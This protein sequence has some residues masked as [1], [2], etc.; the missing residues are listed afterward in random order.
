MSKPECIYPASV[1]DPLSARMADDLGFELGMF[2]GSVASLTVLGD[3]DLILLTLSEFAEQSYRINRACQL[4]LLVDSDHGYGNALNVMRTVEELETAGV[5][6]LSIED[7]QLPVA[8]GDPGSSKLISIEEGIGKMHA[9]VQARSDKSML[10]AARTSATQISNLDDAKARIREYQRTGVDA[11]FIVGLKDRSEL[12]AIASVATLP[13]IIGG[14]DKSV[15]DREYLADHGVRVCLQGHQPVMAAIQS[16][17]ETL[18]ALRNG[19]APDTIT[20]LPAKD[21]LGTWTRQQA[22][23]DWMKQYLTADR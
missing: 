10:L 19:Q 8:Y 9:A 7:T 13:L 15:M 12:E 17:Y 21:Q 16:T 20:G 6:A 5:S 22:F 2:A 4:P 23:K 1:F 11:L 3:P 14:A 18:A